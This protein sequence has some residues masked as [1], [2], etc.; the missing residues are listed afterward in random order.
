LTI[1]WGGASGLVGKWEAG[2]CRPNLPSLVAW[3]SG[4]NCD[5][6]IMTDTVPPPLLSHGD[7]FRTIRDSGCRLEIMPR[8]PC[9]ADT[10]HLRAAVA[11]N[12]EAAKALA[13]LTGVKGP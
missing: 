1:W 2:L 11:A 6:A 3:A 4:L 5:L 8:Q 10:A 13:V 12:L 7:L 9:G